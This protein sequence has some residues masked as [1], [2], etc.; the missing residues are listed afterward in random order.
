[1]AT[2]L[3]LR[4]QANSTF[5]SPW[6]SASNPLKPVRSLESRVRSSILPEKSFP[7]IPRQRNIRSAPHQVRNSRRVLRNQRQRPLPP[8]IGRASGGQEDF[9]RPAG[10]R[11][12][13][14]VNPVL[15][16]R[17]FLARLVPILVL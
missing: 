3:P 1:M 2:F 5:S 7:R 4:K 15:L 9:A 6:I 10:H 17:I 13:F 14:L 12:R 8:R 16:S 11:A